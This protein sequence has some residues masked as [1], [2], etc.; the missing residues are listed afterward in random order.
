MSVVEGDFAE[1]L[2]ARAVVFLVTLAAVF[3]FLVA[4]ADQGLGVV[5]A[6]VGVAV[7]GIPVIGIAAGAVAVVGVVVFVVDAAVVAVAGL[8]GENF[9]I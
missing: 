7:V 3:A 9:L 6:V 5:D 8:A 1:I 4:F 2:V